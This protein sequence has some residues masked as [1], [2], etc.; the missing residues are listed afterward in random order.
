VELEKEKLLYT[1]G[2]NS[3]R[4]YKY[5]S[6]KKGYSIGILGSNGLGKST[7]L[8]I[9]SGDIKVNGKMFIGDEMYKYMSLLNKSKIK[10]AYKPQDINNMHTSMTQLTIFDL[11]STNNTFANYID[12]FNLSHLIDR[13]INCLSGGELQRFLIAYTCSQNANSYI[14]DEPSAYLDIKQRITISN[15]IMN[16]CCDDDKYL[17]CVEHDLCILDYICDYI[18]CLYGVPGCY[19][20]TTSVYSVKNG[21]NNYLDGYFSKE[22]VKFRNESI[23]FHKTFIEDSSYN[24]TVLYT[25]QSHKIIYQNF[26]LSIDCGEIK[27]CEI[28]LL[29]GENGTGK[30]SFIKYLSLNKNFISSIKAQDPYINYDGTVLS[31]LESKINNSL[32]D[33]LFIMNVVKGLGIDNLYENNVNT[34]SGGQMQ[35]LSICVCLGINATIYLLDEPSAFIDVEDRCKLSK[36]LKQF[37]YNYKKNIFIVEHDFTLGVNIADKAIVFSG[38]PGIECFAS[39]PM[40]LA[41]GINMFL[42]NMNVTMRKDIINGKHSINKL[43]SQKDMEQKNANMYF[44]I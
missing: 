24:D 19:G 38:K 30:T 31:Y 16:K 26:S 27:M 40:K 2:E 22:N 37:V 17:I 28:T 7:I 35:K 41:I 39:K 10:I 32:S 23:N 33:P 36:I 13:K 43:N 9:L 42:K 5:P 34:L 1:Y 29:I 12:D 3:F 6:I 25:Y 18:M 14:F 21:I 15:I 8:K 11:L 20:V 4:I 44:E